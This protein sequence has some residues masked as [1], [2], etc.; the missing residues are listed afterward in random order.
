MINKLRTWHNSTIGEKVVK[1]LQKNRFEAMYFATG[2][3]AVDYILKQIPEGAKVGVGGSSTLREIG[4]VGLLRQ[5]GFLLYD[6]NQPDLSAEEKKECRYKQLSSDVFLTSS[7]AITLK[8]ELVNKDGIGNR[9][10]AMFFGPQKV[11]IVAGIN[12]VVRDLDEAEQRIKNVAAPMNSKRHETP[13]PCIKT[14]QCADCQTATRICN[15]TTIIHKCPPLT[16]IQVVII[17]ENL[18]F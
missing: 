15:I 18:G 5:K 14:G 16:K 9:V 3:E 17:G 10:A 1:A 8:G 13:N 6:H 2:Q 12:K 4:L 11:I 7:N